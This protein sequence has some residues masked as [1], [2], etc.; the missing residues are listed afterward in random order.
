MIK[1]AAALDSFDQ[2]SLDSGLICADPSLAQ[3]S[4]KEETD[5]N[6]IVDRFMKTGVLP[7]PVR[8]PQYV[9]YEGV[10]DFQSAMNVVRQADENF[11]KM[12]AKVRARFHNSPQEFLEFFAN[13]ENHAEAVRLGL[14]VPDRQIPDG[15][16]GGDVA[17][18]AGVTSPA[19]G[20]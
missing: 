9:D 5:I 3:Q 10:F 11:M 13:P 20:E 17:G 8:M 4:F 15:Q 1:L 16:A 18:A 14:V 2:R 19:V 12:D 6:T 7:D